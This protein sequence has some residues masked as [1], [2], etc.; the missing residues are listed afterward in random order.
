M[1]G[2]DFL[3][4]FRASGAWSGNGLDISLLYRTQYYRKYSCYNLQVVVTENQLRAVFP[5]HSAFFL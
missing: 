2:G 1:G 4:Q 5:S 3:I